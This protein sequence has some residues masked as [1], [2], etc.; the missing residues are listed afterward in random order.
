MRKF[1]IYGYKE[2]KL[3]QSVTLHKKHPPMNVS[4]DIYAS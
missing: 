3:N 2:N 1:T 4:S